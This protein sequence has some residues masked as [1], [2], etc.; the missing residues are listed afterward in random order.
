MRQILNY[1]DIIFYYRKVKN[2]EQ[3]RQNHYLNGWQKLVK[4]IEQ[5]QIQLMERAIVENIS[6]CESLKKTIKDQIKFLCDMMKSGTRVKYGAKEI[7]AINGEI[8]SFRAK[9][10][11][12]YNKKDEAYI[13]G[14]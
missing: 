3:S 1:G 14:F 5:F 4:E 7:D 6:N 10:I 13:K 2:M 9:L 11:E 8:Y 12:K